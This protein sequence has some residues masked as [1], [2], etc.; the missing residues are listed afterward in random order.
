MCDSGTG[1]TAACAIIDVGHLP[2]GLI[3]RV[4]RPQFSP[5]ASVIGIEING[6]TDGEVHV[7]SNVAI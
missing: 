6:I 7:L 1:N 3:G 4:V 5:C 2:S